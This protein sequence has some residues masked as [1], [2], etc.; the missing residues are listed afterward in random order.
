M[1]GDGEYVIYTALAWRNK[2]F[3]SAVEFVWGPDAGEYAVRE[4]SGRVK[5]FRNFKV[6]Q[7]DREIDRENHQILVSFSWQCIFFV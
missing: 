1:C 7:T 5:L 4:T 2:T 3:G 6:R